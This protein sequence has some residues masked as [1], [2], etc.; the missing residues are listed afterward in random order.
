MMRTRLL[1]LVA[2]F[3]AV[4]CTARAQLPSLTEVSVV[5]TLD[6][7]SQPVLYWAPDSATRQPTVLFVF[8]HSWSSDYTQDNS[9][10][11]REAVKR[12]WIYLHANF[13]G[14]NRSPKACGSR[15]ARRDILDA[16]DFAI[17][18][19]NV[20]KSRVY[21]AG[22][23]GGGHM[24]M[25]MAGHHPDRFSAVSAWVGIS[26]LSEWYRFHIKDGKPQRYAQMILQ[27]FGKPPGADA[28]TDAEY[29]DRSP[30]FHMRRVGN[31]PVD[32]HAGVNDGHTGSVPVRHSLQ[33]F[34]EIARTHGS[35]L[36]TEAEMEMLWTAR[37]L[38]NPRPS[39]V[40]EDPSYGRK[41]FLRRQSNESRVT[42]F[43]GG[44]ESLVE[45]ACEWLTKRRRAVR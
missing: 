15:F 27:S 16:M 3:L 34:N 5:S 28:A 19:F 29:R 41:T 13:R 43:D 33:A 44:H 23:S 21:L 12:G 9:K 30:L 36:V 1:C 22:V 37:Q 42:I 4:P 35:A 39:D 10:W 38:A 8:L 17:G 18:R 20:D 32:I 7:E 40:A 31:L 24:A 11:Q 2:M 26:D 25:L 6:G 45:P 14:A